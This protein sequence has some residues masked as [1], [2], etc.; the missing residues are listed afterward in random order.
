MSYT[1]VRK[2]KTYN[3]RILKIYSDKKLISSAVPCMGWFGWTQGFT[4]E[5]DRICCRRKVLENLY[6][7]LGRDCSKEDWIESVKGWDEGKHIYGVSIDRLTSMF[8]N[9]DERLLA[10]ESFDN[11]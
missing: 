5:T 10:I 4:N 1:V 7:L 9:D 11:I 6:W 8:F 2:N 3:K